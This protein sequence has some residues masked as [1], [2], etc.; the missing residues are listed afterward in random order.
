VLLDW[1]RTPGCCFDEEKRRF[2]LALARKRT[3]F[4]FPND[5]VAFARKLQSRLQKKHKKDSDEGRALRA[6]REIRVQA[7]PSWE[8]S[9]IELFFW[10]IRDESDTDF[11]GMNWGGWLEKW[12]D[13]LPESGRFQGV[14]G[15]VTTL[16]DLTAKDYVESD[17]LDLDHLS[18][19]E[20]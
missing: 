1:K 15:L 16:A 2:S 18:A 17:P 19:Q 12:L 3:R 13:L 8:A 10:F 4:A 6:L 7:A 11:E 20:S 14:D 9:E 5:F